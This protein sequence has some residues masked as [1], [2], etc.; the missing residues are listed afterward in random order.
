MTIFQALCTVLDIGWQRGGDGNGFR[1]GFQRFPRW[2]KRGVRAR[3]AN[4]RHPESKS[5]LTHSVLLQTSSLSSFIT[6]LRQEE[7]RISRLSSIVNGNT[8]TEGHDLNNR[9]KRKYK[10]NGTTTL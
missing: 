10:P 1:D 7:T 5:H 4:I 9:R 6:G 8:R 3:R 2:G